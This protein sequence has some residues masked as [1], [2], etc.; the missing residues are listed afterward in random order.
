MQTMIIHNNTAHQI[1]AIRRVRLSTKPGPAELGYGMGEFGGPEFMTHTVTL[2]PGSNALSKEDAEVVA[3]QREKN[4]SFRA[5]FER[6]VEGR[7]GNKGRPEL[8]EGSQTGR[9]HL[10]RA[11]RECSDAATL[12]KYRDAFASDKGLA[13]LV[14]T[15]L[16]ATTVTADG[17]PIA[18]DVKRDP[19]DP[20]KGAR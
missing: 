3:E 13:S 10:E 2:K 11:I 6:L 20:R 15:Q 17:T 18:H 5:R 4:P 1:V 7:F 9:H 12:R 14:E 19:A 16:A 8:E